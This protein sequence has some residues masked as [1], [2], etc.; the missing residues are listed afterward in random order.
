MSFSIII[1]PSP[2]PSIFNT[3]PAL[4]TT[5]VDAANEGRS[6]AVTGP[7]RPS[8]SV[9]SAPAPATAAS[10][11]MPATSIPL[12]TVGASNVA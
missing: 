5:S 8:A 9:P 1:V 6:S 2:S 12:V 4:T 10:R 3:A 7:T 11:R